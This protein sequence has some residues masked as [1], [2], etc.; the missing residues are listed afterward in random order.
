MARVSAPI[1]AKRLGISPQQ[2]GKLCKAGKLDG[3]RPHDRGWWQVELSPKK[4]EEKP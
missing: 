2:V 4:K 1:A 3:I